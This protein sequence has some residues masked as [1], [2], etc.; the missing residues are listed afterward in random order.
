MADSL[1]ASTRSCSRCRREK[2]IDAFPLV[3][4][5]T[6]LERSVNRTMHCGE[7]GVKDSAAKKLSRPSKKVRLEADKENGGSVP[8]EILKKPQ[9][10]T[11]QACALDLFLSF[12]GERRNVMELE[13]C[14][15]ISLLSLVR[16]GGTF[17]DRTPMRSSVVIDPDN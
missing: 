11:L 7:C 10:E 8:R 14:V 2:P 13:A 3:K 4:R 15:D 17:F 9:G 6:P 12:V 16:G 5:G 1:C